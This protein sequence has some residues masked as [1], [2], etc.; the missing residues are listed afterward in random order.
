MNSNELLKTY[1]DNTHVLQS[2]PWGAFKSAMGTKCVQAGDAQMTLHKIP[3]SPFKVGYLPKARPVELDLEKIYEIGKKEN[4]ISV[5]LDVPHTT[6]NYQPPTINYQLIKGG[7]IFAQSTLLLDLTK[8]DDEILANM[9]EKTR[10]NIGLARRKGVTVKAFESLEQEGAKEAL[11]NFVKL[12]EQTAARQKFFVHSR[13]YYKSCFETLS[14]E[15]MAYL[16]ESKVENKTAAS[17]ILFRYEDTFYYP[18]GESNYELRSYMASNLLMW[19]STQLGKKLGCKVFDLWGASN[20]PDDE[21]D[22]WYGFTRFKMS[23][24]AIHVNLAPTY[25]LIINKALYMSFSAINY[26][27]WKLLRA[28]R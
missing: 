14:R 25:D 23:F 6:S 11:E 17:W 15:K 4:C 1:F 18:Y 12:Q 9:H 13:D 16:I 22:P 7:H 26:L 28:T 5:K 20:N 24:G 8:T 21:K 10:Y 19:E 27:R 2:E 3:L